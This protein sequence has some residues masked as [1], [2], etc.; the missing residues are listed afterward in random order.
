MDYCIVTPF[1]CDPTD[2]LSD[3]I[4]GLSEKKCN[5]YPQSPLLILFI[6]HI[7]FRFQIPVGNIIQFCRYSIKLSRLSAELEH[8]THMWARFCRARCL[9]RES[10]TR[11]HKS[12]V[13]VNQLI[14]NQ[15]FVFYLLKIHRW[16][17]V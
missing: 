5:H 14:G 2:L 9:G 15:C 13:V 12:T 7:L 4:H 10:C 8:L 16:E 11:V 1:I 6:M 3:V 17:K